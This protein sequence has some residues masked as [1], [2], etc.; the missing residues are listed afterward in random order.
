MQ[1]II[2]HSFPLLQ[3]SVYRVHCVL[4]TSLNIALSLTYLPVLL[5][6]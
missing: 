6:V 3:Q 2:L 1:K 5:S 4:Q